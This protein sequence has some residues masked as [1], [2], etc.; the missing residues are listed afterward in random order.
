MSS[1]NAAMYIAVS[2]LRAQSANL[3][4][5]STNLANSST[6]GYKEVT[7]NFSTLVTDPL[8]VQRA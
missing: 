6:V 3:S 5:I 4:M 1:G 2:A 7:A 8:W